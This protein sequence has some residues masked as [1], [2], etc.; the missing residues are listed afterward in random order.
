MFIKPPYTTPPIGNR[1]ALA[2]LNIMTKTGTSLLLALFCLL[3]QPIERVSAEEPQPANWRQRL[4]RARRLH[5]NPNNTNA[6]TLSEARMANIAGLKVAIWSPQYEHGAMPLVVF[7]HGFSGINIQSAPLM[8]ALANAGYLVLA[9]NHKD[10]FTNRGNIGKL[11]APLSKPGEWNERAF[12]NRGEDIKK[13]LLALQN[14][15]TWK[16]KVD[17]SRVALV[18]HS[19][20]GYTVL[21]LAGAWPSWKMQDP[22]PR[23]VLALSPY[24]HPFNLKGDISELDLPVMYQT[25]T[26]DLGVAPFLKG[27]KGTFAKTS[28]PAYLVEIAGANH[29]S[30]TNLNKQKWKEDLINHYSVSFLNKFVKDD[31]TAKPEAKLKGVSVLMI[32]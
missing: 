1:T 3:L 10:A 23:A 2:T 11:Q 17:W 20:G 31:P 32:K 9:P 18:G 4:S 21:A 26:T 14:D 6:Q 7:S 19:L 30:W 27:A 29:F 12:K 5:H 8:K 25:G 13:L 16:N 24:S 15:S 28:S 22:R